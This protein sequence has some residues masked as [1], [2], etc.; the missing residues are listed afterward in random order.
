[1]VPLGFLF[2]ATAVQVCIENGYEM[3]EGDEAND[4]SDAVPSSFK[5]CQRSEDAKVFVRVGGVG[6]SVRTHLSWDDCSHGVQDGMKN[7]LDTPCPFI[8]GRWLYH[9]KIPQDT[10]EVH[11]RSLSAECISEKFTQMR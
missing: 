1:M 4:R 8:C 10:I 6:R 3:A 2:R 7:V 9:R 11:L 5:M